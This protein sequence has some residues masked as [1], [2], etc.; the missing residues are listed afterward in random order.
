MA[1]KNGRVTEWKGFYDCKLTDAEKEQFALWDVADSDVWLGL[2]SYC[3]QG[4]KVTCSHNHTNGTF[5]AAATGTSDNKHNAGYTL[6]AFAPTMYDAVR[7]LLF[8]IDVV[9]PPKW[10]E[11]PAM[12]EN[13]WG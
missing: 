12:D 4:Y 13:K 1:Q 3:E 9:L 8:K 11:R 6:S 7:L 2:G 10:H 5:T